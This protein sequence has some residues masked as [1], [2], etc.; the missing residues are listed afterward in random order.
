MT[1]KNGVG[2]AATLAPGQDMDDSRFRI[3]PYQQI[4]SSCSGAL[5]TSLFMTPLDV[6]KTRL[7]AQQKLLL[8]NKCYLYCNGLMD[9]ICPCA[10][11]MGPSAVSKPTLHFT[12]T[13]DAFSKIS[14]HEGVRSLWSGLGPTLVL[15]L[16]TT[17]IYFVAY[18]QFR[19]R[20]K[21][22]HQSRKG[23]DAELPFWLP[24]TAGGSAR[25]LAVT[26]VNPLELIRTKMQSE[27][28]SYSEVGQ[29]FRSML[30]VQGVLGMWNGFFPTIL[31]DVPFSAIYWTTYETYKKQLNVTQPTFSVSFVGGAISG[32][33]AAFLTVPFDVVKTHQQIAFGERFLYPQNGAKSA[34]VSTFAMM[35]RIFE[36]SGIRGLFTGLTP[37]L[38]KV[39]P[40]CAIMIA[41]FE[42]GK[43]FFYSYNVKRYQEKHGR[44]SGAPP[45][46]GG[47]TTVGASLVSSTMPTS[48]PTVVAAASPSPSHRGRVRF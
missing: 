31:R 29:A 33:V 16:P 5:V 11:N 28:L 34:T 9:H 6:I 27:R 44:V 17:V 22:L 35:R 8:S 10:P 14:R 38:V 36:A 45:L 43:N 4:L 41:S 15:A 19:I 18:E 12:G 26:I 37:R 25:V 39:A 24:L 47:G 2:S 20:L 48:S 21:E 46:G 42:Y 3:R 23:K 1:A 32:G 40:A 13:I 7:Q 30:R